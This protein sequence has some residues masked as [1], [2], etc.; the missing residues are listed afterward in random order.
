MKINA[1]RATLAALQ[2]LET[3]EEV[4]IPS[5]T[6]VFEAV[7]M[8][9]LRADILG[10]KIR[11]SLDDVLAAIRSRWKEKIRGHRLVSAVKV[12]IMKDGSLV[13]KDPTSVVKIL[14]P[15]TG[16]ARK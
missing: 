7:F 10:I 13:A 6:S 16:R 1:A 2:E 15:K 12:E 14:P 9:V 5:G 8:I 3:K 4:L 11:G